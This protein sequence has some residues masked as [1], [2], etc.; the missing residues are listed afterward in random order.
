MDFSE[1]IAA[2]MRHYNLQAKD[3]ADRCGVQ[4]T[5]ITH[6]LN[7]RNRPSVSFL[8]QLSDAYP[9]INTRWLL[10]GRGSMFTNV[11][12]VTSNEAPT[13]SPSKEQIEQLELSG[14]NLSEN[15]ETAPE[16]PLSVVTNVTDGASENTLGKS[17]HA[18]IPL[19]QSNKPVR[20]IVIF[21][22]DGTFKSFRPDAS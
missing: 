9:E 4:R 3:L 14:G 11:T 7:G 10:H 22:K 17:L 21:Y 12:S 13:A 16:S 5:A 18:P 2:V 20:E 19:E 8:G 15:S 6:I 1:R